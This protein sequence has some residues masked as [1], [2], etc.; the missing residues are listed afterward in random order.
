MKKK[1]L[2]CLLLASVQIHA[3]KVG[4]LVMATG[5]YIQFIEPL[6]NSADNYFCPED[7]V[8]YFIFTDGQPPVR[9]DVIKTHQGRLGWPLDTMMRCRAYLNGYDAWK[10]MDYVFACDADMLFVDTVGR[11]IL[12]ERV[13][14]QHPGYVGGRGTPETRSSSTAYIRPHEN[15]YYFAGGFHGGSTAEFFKLASTMLRNIEIDL[16]KGI[17]AVWHD[18]SHLNRYFVDNPP[19][20]ILNP[21]YCYPEE[22][23]L[24]Y[25]K[26]LLALCKNHAEMRK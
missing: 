2:C 8:T 24:P 4:L 18:E 13:A 12:S 11:E 3:A 7:E 22:L 10:D 6:I 26:R 21:E 16:E 1:L 17:V 19:T 9:A 15:S 5:K 14:T 25:H 23:H 20:K